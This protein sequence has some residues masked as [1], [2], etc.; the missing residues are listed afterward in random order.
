M[1]FFYVYN[2]LCK[3]SLVCIFEIGFDG[4]SS[5]K[6]K[7]DL[8]VEALDSGKHSILKQLVWK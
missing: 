3:R 2:F 5:H 6:H 4:I 1:I 7:K 8:L